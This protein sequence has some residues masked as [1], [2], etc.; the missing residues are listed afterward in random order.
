MEEIKVEP[1]EFCSDA[2]T[3]DNEQYQYGVAK[4]TP[5]PCVK[6]ESQIIMEQ[7]KVEP[8]DY[9]LQTKYK[10]ENEI[11]PFTEVLIKTESQIV[12]AKISLD[13]QSQ[14]N[15]NELQVEQSNTKKQ[16][17][18]ADL[19]VK[20]NDKFIYDSGE[21]P[22]V[23]EICRNSYTQ[24]A[25]LN[26]HMSK[27]AGL[28]P[29]LCCHC[30][31]SFSQKSDL[32]RHILIHGGEKQFS[33]NVCKRSFYRKSD[34]NMHM[35]IHTGHRPFMCNICGKLFNRKFYLKAH[36]I[37]HRSQESLKRTCSN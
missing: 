25:S 6:S 31:K 5:L 3:S 18:N 30:S 4:E 22:F 21:K 29:F 2:K 33:C 37:T 14:D 17:F 28:K 8:E 1:E 34:M 32:S 7:I 23:C 24:K 16:T 35:R 26:R 36:M 9:C 19:E 15:E 27:H 11:L 12:D 13:N 10:A 20:D